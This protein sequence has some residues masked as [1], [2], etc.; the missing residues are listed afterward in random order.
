MTLKK[1]SKRRRKIIAGKFYTVGRGPQGYPGEY[2]AE[3]LATGLEG[4]DG[5]G[6]VAIIWFENGDFVIDY[7]SDD[8]ESLTDYDI[9]MECEAPAHRTHLSQLLAGQATIYKEK[10]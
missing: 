4:S 10:L 6:N 1:R 5:Y 8:G 9:I 7:F 2:V 3:I